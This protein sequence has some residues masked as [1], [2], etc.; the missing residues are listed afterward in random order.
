MASAGWC[1]GIGRE[2]ATP[3]T[4]IT[5]Y[6]TG[7]PGPL[8]FDEQY[9]RPTIQVRVRGTSYPA[10]RDK[11]DEVAAILNGVI[12]ETVGA[13][14][15]IGVWM[16]SDVMDIGRDDNNRIRLTAN[17]EMHRQPEE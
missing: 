14:H 17:F 7:G 4:T 3:D 5:I 11:L 12:N 15:V 9:R 1:V 10:T 8:L 2:P 13:F 6:D 16:T